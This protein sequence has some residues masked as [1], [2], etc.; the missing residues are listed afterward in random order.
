MKI[1]LIQVLGVFLLGVLFSCNKEDTT[2]NNQG[3]FSNGCFILNEGNFN[4]GNAS[5]DFYSFETES[6]KSDLFQQANNRPLGDVFQSMIVYNQRAYLVINNSGKIEVCNPATMKSIAT[7]SGLN[8]PRYILPVSDIKFYVT[9]LYDKN[10]AVVNPM[11]LSITKK[12]PLKY[13]SEE[14]IAANNKVFVCAM[15]SEFVYVINPI[16][17]QIIDSISV[18]YSPSSIVKGSNGNLFVLSE[19]SLV[20]PILNSSLTELNPGNHLILNQ[21]TLTSNGG[22]CLRTNKSGSELYF[23]YNKDVYR[24]TVGSGAIPPDLLI[25]GQARNF[26]GLNIRPDNG[27]IFVFDAK[28]YVQRGALII[29]DKS[30]NM[31]KELKVGIIPSAAYF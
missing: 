5:I 9:D 17:D 24:Y 2:P 21:W 14:L 7:I 10:V 16:N 13:W 29:Y 6:I 19:G 4:W 22:R 8:S 3:D 27:D 26:Y 1:K 20:S 28:D 25:S 12:I 31:K 15:K 23:I 18:G 11:N 30:G